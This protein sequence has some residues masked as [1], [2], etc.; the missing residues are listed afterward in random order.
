MIDKLKERAAR[1]AY[2]PLLIELYNNLGDVEHHRELG[3]AEKLA[4][5]MEESKLLVSVIDKDGY[6]VCVNSAWLRA[7]GWSFNEMVEFNIFDLVHEDDQKRTMKGFEDI[8]MFA[9]DFH[10]YRHFENR[11]RKKSGEYA[12]IIWRVYSD[13]KPHRQ[14]GS[15]IAEVKK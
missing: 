7:L 9:D 6:F 15:Y 1:A 12:N 10:K 3:V 8:A 2:A 14:Y 13:Y 5:I 11:Y 4:H